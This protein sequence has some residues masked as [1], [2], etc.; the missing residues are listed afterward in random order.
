MLNLA[1]L[2]ASRD[3]REMLTRPLER[4]H[5][6]AKTGVPPYDV[7]LCFGASRQVPPCK[8]AVALSD[9]AGAMERLKGAGCTV[10]A[11]GTAE[12]DTVS[13]SSIGERA[14]AVSLQ[15]ELTLPNGKKLEPCEIPVR[16]G[17]EYS[18]GGNIS[19]RRT[20]S[21]SGGSSDDRVKNCVCGV[22]NRRADSVLNNSGDYR[23][24]GCKIDGG[25]ITVA[26]ALLLLCGVDPDHGYD[27]T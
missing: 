18:S 8:A 26:A 11:C 9:D 6:A 4:Y 13:L 15:R 1:I 27:L 17:G 12:T 3:R 20:H 24:R 14:A 22:S 16:L 23:C 5:V 19:N 7:V 10:I 25:M 2:G 21:E